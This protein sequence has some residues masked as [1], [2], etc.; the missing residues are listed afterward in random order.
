MIRACDDHGYV[1]GDACPVCGDEGR[2]VLDDDRRVTLSKYLS[3]A[4]R[5]FPENAGLALDDRGWVD[6][7]SLVDAVTDRYP[8]AE[9]EHV[10]AVVA[11]DSKGRFERRDRRIRA[12]YGHSVDV[13]LESTETSVPDRLYHGTAPRNVASIFD[14]GLE[15]MSRQTV[16][17]SETPEEAREVGRRHADEPVVLVVDA[18]AMVHDGFE[19]D[20]R[21]TET[22]TV[23]RVPPKYIGR[24]DD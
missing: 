8:W 2:H 24:S 9:P 16:H 23:G 13:E 7:E 10:D 11:T 1:D 19:I 21:G 6:D 5:H 3:G 14:R 17:L 15:P 20:K 18:R 4:L 22:Y 12:A